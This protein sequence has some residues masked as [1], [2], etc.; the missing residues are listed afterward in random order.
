MA[1][2]AEIASSEMT[3]IAPVWLM[4]THGLTQVCGGLDPAVWVA[5]RWET[6]AM[7]ERGPGDGRYAYLERE[8]RWLLAA[9][10]EQAR[11]RSEI[12]DRYL[13]GTRLRL[14][15]VTLP[16]RVVY[17]LGQKV[18]LVAGDPE[19]VKLTNIYLTAEEYDTFATL[20]G[21]EIAKER[22]VMPW[23]PADLAVDRF[24]GRLDGL[25][26][27]EAEL[28]PED[29]LHELPPFALADVTHDDRYSGGALAHASER[30]LKT[31]LSETPGHR[32]R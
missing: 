16:D 5:R 29:G 8:Q 19:R 17:K 21:A 26:L 27:A 18:R 32:P 28:G 11:F 20:S 31:L 14:R 25:V 3:P 1:T 12:L 2:I 24:Q 6:L 9:V 15:R 22:F 4:L 13:Q 10:P 23:G 30:E 7:S